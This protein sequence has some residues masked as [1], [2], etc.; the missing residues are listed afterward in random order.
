M[1]G[2]GPFQ[3]RL[4]PVQMA[5]KPSSLKGRG[6]VMFPLHEHALD[7]LELARDIARARRPLHARPHDDPRGRSVR[8]RKLRCFA[9]LF[10]GGPSRRSREQQSL[11]LSHISATGEVV[12]V[13]S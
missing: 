6:K 10:V 5:L 12:S 1:R 13:E 4:G 2:P 8:V 7:A 11:P 3:S 9:F